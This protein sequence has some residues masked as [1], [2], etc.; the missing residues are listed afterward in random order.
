MATPPLKTTHVLFRSHIQFPRY[1]PFNYAN[2]EMRDMVPFRKSGHIFGTQM[3]CFFCLTPWP[4][5]SI[6]CCIVEL[7]LVSLS[8]TCDKS[9]ERVEPGNETGEWSLGMRQEMKPGKWSLCS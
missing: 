2:L 3:V 4:V 8:G 5:L 6:F 1:A 7:L 9:L